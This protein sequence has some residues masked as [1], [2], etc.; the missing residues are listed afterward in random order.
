MIECQSLAL[1]RAAVGG[2]GFGLGK[3]M[4]FLWREGL[5]VM[6]TGLSQCHLPEFLEVQCAVIASLEGLVG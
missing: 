5:P 1:L 4:S 6:D 3:S 2:Y